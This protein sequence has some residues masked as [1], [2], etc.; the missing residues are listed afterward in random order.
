MQ[1]D[2]DTRYPKPWTAEWDP[3]TP[4]IKKKGLSSEF[5]E[6]YRVRQKAP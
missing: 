5:R 1:K 3:S 4:G 2:T 6:G